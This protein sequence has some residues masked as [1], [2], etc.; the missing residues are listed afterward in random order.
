MR[1]IIKLWVGNHELVT[2]ENVQEY[3]QTLNKYI[4]SSEA[5]IRNH[6]EVIEFGETGFALV[7]TERTNTSLKELEDAMVKAQGYTSNS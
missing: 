2:A 4:G 5:G 6:C 7:G 1:K 3:A